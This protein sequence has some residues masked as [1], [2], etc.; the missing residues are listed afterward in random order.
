MADSVGIKIEKYNKAAWYFECKGWWVSCV[1][2]NSSKIAALRDDIKYFYKNFCF[3]E[4]HDI[5][6]ERIK[7][8]LPPWAEEITD[9]YTLIKVLARI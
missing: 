5:F 1:T 2:V 9:R 8:T 7:Y 4:S 6:N 3:E